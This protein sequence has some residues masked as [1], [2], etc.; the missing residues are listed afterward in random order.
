MPI[1]SQ[2][3]NTDLNTKIN[4]SMKL[5]NSTSTYWDGNN[6]I[7]SN[8]ADAVSANDAVSKKYFEEHAPSGSVT[9][10]IAIGNGGTGAQ[11]ATDALSKSSCIA[12][13]ISLII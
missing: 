7:L 6:K 13:C 10:P 12:S 11:N 2:E 5:D 3:L 8:I 9:F 1:S 4:N